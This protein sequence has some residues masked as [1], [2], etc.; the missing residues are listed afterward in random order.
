MNFNHNS[1]PKELNK[2]A[3]CSSKLKS[4]KLNFIWLPY[5]N[6][7]PSVGCLKNS[8][9]LT[10]EYKF[11]KLKMGFITLL[12]CWKMFLPQFDGFLF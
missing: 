4:L 9:K 8:L 12:T 3:C 6:S 5:I 10:V 7:C 2:P 11:K 1:V